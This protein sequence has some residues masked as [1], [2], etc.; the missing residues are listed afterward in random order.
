MT[1]SI[2]LLAVG[3]ALVVVLPATAYAAASNVQTA[4]ASGVQP[5]GT[6]AATA[7]AGRT[8]QAGSPNADAQGSEITVTGQ[9]PVAEPPSAP[10]VGSRIAREP[11]M[12]FGTISS[13]NVAGFVPGSGMDPFAGATKN[14]STRHCRSDNRRLSEQAACRLVP[15]VRAFNSG[16]HDEARNAIERL[17]AS[18]A[19]TDE[20]RYIAAGFLYRIAVAAGDDL[21]R[22]E[23]LRMMI[24]TNVMPEAERLL[25]YRALVSWALRR[26]DREAAAG[27]LEQL[28]PLAPQ[29]TRSRVNLAALYAERGRVAEASALVRTAIGIAQAR[30]EPVPTEWV[31]FL[32]SSQ[33]TAAAAPRRQ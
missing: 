18:E 26:N 31:N 30:G 24:A 2:N 29:D 3:A 32:A 33:G 13:G 20:E 22:D 9:R 12:R 23:A 28:V 16:S 15:I 25:A 6:Q 4:Q 17:Y 21:D 10:P 27:L 7:A 1:R 5:A 11:L 8:E 14:V 19:A